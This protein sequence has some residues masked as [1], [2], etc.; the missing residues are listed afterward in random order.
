MSR[1]TATRTIAVSVTAEDIAAGIRGS[2]TACPMALA[3]GRLGFPSISIGLRSM[4]WD[5]EGRG[6]A[7]T[8]MPPEVISF[9]SRFDHGRPVEP[10][11][12]TIEV[13]A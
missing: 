1:A 9:G 11:S 12:F 10:F 8:E 13:P 5:S 6:Y 3:L 2:S 4:V 7:V